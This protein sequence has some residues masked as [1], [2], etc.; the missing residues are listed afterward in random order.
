M[1]V[2]VTGK[3]VHVPSH[4]REH[5]VRKLTK[6]ERFDNHLLSMQV[7]FSRARNPRVPESHHVE[8]TC[9]APAHLLRATADATN[10]LDAVDRVLNRLERQVKKL[11]DRRLAARRRTPVVNQDIQRS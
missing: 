8:V 4:L 7:E 5:A 11:S 10:P 9:A 6:V 3:N 1:Q 2:T